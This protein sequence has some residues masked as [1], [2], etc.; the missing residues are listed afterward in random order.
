MSKLTAC[1]Y[2]NCQI[3]NVQK[4]AI[5]LNNHEIHKYGFFF[6]FYLSTYILIRELL[7][8]FNVEYLKKKKKKNVK[9]ENRKI[10]F[11]PIPEYLNLKVQQ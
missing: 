5:T 6:F 11:G 2:F 9:L 7:R 1:F 8:D 3:D 10:D 4:N